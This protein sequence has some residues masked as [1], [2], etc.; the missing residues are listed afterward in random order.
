MGRE[1]AIDRTR[2]NLL[3]VSAAR[4]AGGGWLRD[5]R[6]RTA[7]G[8]AASLGI[9]RVGRKRRRDIEPRERSGRQAPRRALRCD[10][11]RP[12]GDRAGSNGRSVHVMAAETARRRDDSSGAR[13]AVLD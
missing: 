12:N 5:A 10:G 13:H 1:R 11:R 4:K 2:R 9:V 7:A 3:D 8:R 6:P